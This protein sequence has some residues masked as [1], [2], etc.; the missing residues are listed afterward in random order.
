MKKIFMMFLLAAMVMPVFA[1]A[2][3]A[4]D[5]RC[6]MKDSAH[7][8]KMMEMMEKLEKVELTG[9][10]VIK[11]EMHPT[12]LVGDK[13]YLLGFPVF[14]MKEYLADGDTVTIK[15][16]YPPKKKEADFV[17]VTEITK[18]KTVYIIVKGGKPG[19]GHGKEGCQD[20]AC[21]KKKGRKGCP[22]KKGFKNHKGN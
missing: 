1:Q 2:E 13:T 7:H 6:Q 20:G 3:E 12:L 10:L 9:T 14:R 4:G 16:F 21:G 17:V 5:Q 8:A 15:G 22:M 11:E 19:M 18:G